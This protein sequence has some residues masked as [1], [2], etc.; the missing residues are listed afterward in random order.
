MAYSADDIRSNLAT[1]DTT[2]PEKFSPADYVKF[3]EHAPQEKQGASS[4]WYAR[5]QNFTIGY[6]E[7][8]GKARFSRIGQPDEHVLLL[9]DDQL[10]ATVEANGESATVSGKTMVVVPPGDS[11][12]EISGTGRA[13]RLVRTTSEDLASLAI[14]ASSYEKPHENIPRFQQWPDPPGGFKIRSYDLN[15]APLR[16]PPFRLFRCTTFMVN[17]VSPI[18]GPRDPANLSPHTHDDF[19]QCSLVIDGEYTHHI[20]WPWTTNRH[21]WLP[22]DHEQVGSPSLTVI[23]PP[24]LHTSEATSAGRNHLID[25]FAPPRADF[26]AM[27]GWVFNADEYPMPSVE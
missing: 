15:V 7:V 11:S 19:E 17:F 2:P 13:A 22:D 21:N 25:L 23:P 16:N 18:E 8:D 10:S 5:A 1:S 27:E 4:T 24:S 3:Y 14:N 26:S 20:R 9:M 6:T 12:I